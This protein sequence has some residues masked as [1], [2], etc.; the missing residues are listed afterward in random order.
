LWRSEGGSILIPVAVCL[1]GL[2]TFSA[3]TVDNGVM[4]SSRRQAQ[5]AADAGA[6]AAALYLAF[7]D[8][9]DQPGA[10]LAAVE[11]AQLNMV[12]GSQ[13]D[14]TV[15]DITFPPCPPGSPGP[16]DECVRVDVF[17][18][19]RAGG[20]PLPAFFA[21]LAG[22][23]TQGVRATATAQ[24]LY[25]EEADTASCLLPFAIPDRYEEHR[26]SWEDDPDLAADPWGDAVDDSLPTGVVVYPDDSHDLDFDQNRWDP[27]DAYDVVTQQGQHG[28]VELPGQGTNMVDRYARGFYPEPSIDGGLATGFAIGRDRG[29]RMRLKANNQSVIAPSFYYPIVLPDGLGTGASNYRFRIRECTNLTNPIAVGDFITVETGNMVG[30]TNAI[31]TLID[32]DPTAEW[33]PVVGGDPT[34]GGVIN[35]SHPLQSPR[36][37][38]V[39]TFDAHNFM[40]GHRTGRGDI[41]V[42]GFVGVFIE[43]FAAGEISARIMESTVDPSASTTTTNTSTFLRSVVL[44]R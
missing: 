17:R 38:A 7:D 21:S 37:R 25:H 34:S 6:L 19:Q 9:T 42:T 28:G 26:E 23:N 43:D 20:N 24:V 39:L 14:V 35:S 31:Q 10:Q 13:P 36:I 32:E 1:L 3:F 44:V 5:T 41:L 15:A 40:T 2:L 29:M 12:W 16:V 33:D 27:D 30:P 8:G 4:L 18:N 22:V 11:A